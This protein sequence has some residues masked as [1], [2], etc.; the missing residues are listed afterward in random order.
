[1]ITVAEEV[2]YNQNNKADS[3]IS[4]V[5]NVMLELVVLTSQYLK[6]P[7][8]KGY[9]HFDHKLRCSWRDLSLFLTSFLFILV[10]S[11]YTPKNL[12]HPCH[13]P[14]L[15]ACGDN[16]LLIMPFLTFFCRPGILS[17]LHAAYCFW[18]IIKTE[19]ARS[20]EV[21]WSKWLPGFWRT[22]VSS[23]SGSRSPRTWGTV[24]PIHGLITHDDFNLQ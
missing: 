16:P 7:V 9:T 21:L 12:H 8:S 3:T 17:F 11:M 5:L 22:I 14:A 13:I 18:T 24:Y 4:Y 6:S 23:H 15:Y 19:A 1:M 2:N 10:M 20:S